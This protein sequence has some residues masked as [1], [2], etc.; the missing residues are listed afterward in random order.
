MIAELARDRVVILSTHIVSDIASACHQM[1][2]LDHGH[3]RFR[4][5]MAEALKEAEGRVWR[6][7]LDPDL[8]DRISRRYVVT[9]MV[10]DGDALETRFVCDTKEDENWESVRPGLEDAYHCLLGEVSHV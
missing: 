6:A 5:T 4:G 9:A 7:R 8:Y 3:I 2:V 10:Q 1:A